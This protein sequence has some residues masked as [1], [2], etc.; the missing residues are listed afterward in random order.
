[1]G[2]I[3]AVALGLALATSMAAAQVL[4]SGAQTIALN[5]KLAESFTVSL[6]ASAVNF[7]LAAGSATNRR[8]HA[9]SLRPP[10][11]VLGPGR[12]SVGVYAYFAHAAAALTDGAGHNIP[13]PAFFIADN[14]GPRRP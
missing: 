12:T 6:S 7:T 10:R 13:S 5:A 2:R 9:P 4:D 11:G 14:A 8:Q 1:M 3:T